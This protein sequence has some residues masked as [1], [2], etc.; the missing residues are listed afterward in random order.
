MAKKK[1][2]ASNSNGTPA[3]Q[4]ERTTPANPKKAPPNNMPYIIIIG[5]LLVI[6]AY[7]LSGGGSGPAASPSN[8]PDTSTFN[9][10]T[11]YSGEI[12]EPYLDPELAGLFPDNISGMRRVKLMM[13]PLNDESGG[14]FSSRVENSAHVL[15]I[16]DSVQTDFEVEY[17]VYK[18]ESAE[19]A[20]DVLKYYT[21][22]TGWNTVPK[23]FGDVT[24]WIWQGFLE[25]AGRQYGT[26][27]YWDSI[28]NGAFL[29]I[30]RQGT[31]YIAQASADL[32][33]LHGET[34]QDEY[35]IM[36]DVHAPFEKVNGLSVQMFAEAVKQITS[37]ESQV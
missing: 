32:L 8:Q 21:T 15:Y 34:V 36:V 25:G 35:F 20:S 17:S 16:S 19:A 23:Q 31:S 10:A 18:M 5:L 28:N 26:Y 7:L 11:F 30:E 33:C 29:P 4:S 27:F 1:R 14:R 22:E 9:Q 12:P 24:F 13:D 37:Q 3:R 6:I 2:I